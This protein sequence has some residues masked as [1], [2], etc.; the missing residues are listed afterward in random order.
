MEESNL[1]WW[2]M[3]GSIAALAI[4]LWQLFTKIGDKV[5]ALTVLVTDELRKMDVRIARLEARIWP[6]GPHE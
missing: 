3:T 1:V 4:I 2:L 5:D 6:G